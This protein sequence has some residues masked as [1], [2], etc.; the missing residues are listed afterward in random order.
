MLIKRIDSNRDVQ[1]VE[2]LEIEINGIK[3]TITD[4]YGEMKIH[5]HSEELLIKPC[6]ANEV[7]IHGILK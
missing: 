6:C 7:I 3:Y 5:A 4:R 2:R 1:E